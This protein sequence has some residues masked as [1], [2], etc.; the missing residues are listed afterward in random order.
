METAILIKWKDK[1]D[2][3]YK[4]DIDAYVSGVI[5]DVISQIKNNKN[6]IVNSIQSI[7]LYAPKLKT[8]EI[9]IE[10][11][12]SQKED[13]SNNEE[14]NKIFDGIDD[15]FEN[16]FDTI[17][18][19]KEESFLHQATQTD[20]ADAEE[21]LNEISTVSVGTKES[22]DFISIKG[23]TVQYKPLDPIA[24]KEG[25]AVTLTPHGKVKKL[26]NNNKTVTGYYTEKGNRFRLIEEIAKSRARGEDID[27]EEYVKFVK[28]LTP[29]E[30]SFL[31]KCFELY[32]YR[33]LDISP[34]FASEEQ[35]LILD[36]IHAQHADNTE[37]IAKIREKINKP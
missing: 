10:E 17:E 20:T 26:K 13:K 25:D 6:H 2:K 7:E 14:L 32:N 27:N 22:G 1:T 34:Q 9:P 29:K 11:I 15:T 24:I 31:E 19:D 12:E 8:N 23:E 21:E 33:P 30:I 3:K 37:H 4:E 28:S 35:S 16:M 36:K 5:Q 18:K